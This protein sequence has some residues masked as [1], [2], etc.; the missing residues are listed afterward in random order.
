M[1]CGMYVCN[2]V[3]ATCLERQTVTYDLSS[4]FLLHVWHICN[5]MGRTSNGRPVRQHLERQTVTYDL[6]YYAPCV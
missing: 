4:F 6:S 1:C 2:G 3:M 5:S